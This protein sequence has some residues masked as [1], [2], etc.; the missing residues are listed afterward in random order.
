MA[1]TVDEYISIDE[2][3]AAFTGY[4][5]LIETLLSNPRSSG[6]MGP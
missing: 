2:V 5:A 4:L 3:E 1:H 6:M